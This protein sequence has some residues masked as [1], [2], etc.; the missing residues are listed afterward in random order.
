MSILKQLQSLKIHPSGWPFV[1]LLCMGGFLIG[2]FWE[3]PILV[4][5]GSIAVG[6]Y[7]FRFQTPTIPTNQ[8]IITAPVSGEISAVEPI[9]S[10]DIVS[11]PPRQYLKI[12][13]R[14]GLFYPASLHA[15]TSIKIKDKQKLEDASSR[16]IMI[17]ATTTDLAQN[18]EPEDLVMIFSSVMPRWYPECDVEINDTLSQGQVFGFLS[19]GGQMDLYVPS[20]F[21][22]LR[23]VNQICIA[24]ETILAKEA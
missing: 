22:P 19:F 4:M 3:T 11:I 2:A 15:P 20:H 5:V 9:N 8:G 14:C 7:L 12:G 23:I 17:T 1:A 21:S 24:G 10:P 13:I 6:I 18:N 16:K